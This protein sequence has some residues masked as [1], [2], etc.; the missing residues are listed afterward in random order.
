MYIPEKNQD[1]TKLTYMDVRKEISRIY[2]EARPRMGPRCSA[3][4]G[5]C[6]SKRPRCHFVSSERGSTGERNYAK[7]QEIKLAADTIY[8]GGNGDEI[9]T[10]FD[11]FGTEMNAPV[12]NA[13]IAW[14]KNV[15][16]K[17]H[18]VRPGIACTDGKAIDSDDLA[19]NR[20]LVNGCAD[21]GSIAWTAD[22]KHHPDPNCHFWADGLQAVK[23]RGGRGIAAI[24]AWDDDLL[25]KKIMEA[26]AAG[27]V[28]IANDLDCVGLAYMTV[29]GKYDTL[30]G[31]TNPKSA[32]QLKEIFS[33]TK[34]PYILKGIMT[35][36]GAIKAC[37]AGASALVISNHAGN[38]LDQSL[39]TIEVLS[40]IKRAVGND[41]MVLIDGG[42][43]HGEDVF[44]AIA[45][46]AD[47]VL[48]GRPIV[49]CAEGAEAYGVSLY[50]QKIILELKNAM[51]MT[52]CRTLKDITRDKVYI[53]RE[54][55][56]FR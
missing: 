21:V 53:P 43:R 16:P 52:G 27:C 35:P 3:C 26:D 32:I 13:P 9:D 33:C 39:S 49:I 30:P 10:S 7:L 25:P 34:K 55:G 4:V 38:A 23:E 45:M 44:K 1:P 42:F 54:F 48:I 19:Y 18:F 41:I 22:S 50:L 47:G 28:A 8:E 17:S 29:N 12:F 6:D 5:E 11:F 24:K 20:A 37:E 14:I 56:Y 51:R 15:L 31:L 40:D 36:Q 46:G 2:D